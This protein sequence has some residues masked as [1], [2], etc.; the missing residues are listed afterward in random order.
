[1]REEQKKQ[2]SAAQSTEVY[3]QF[4][5]TIT[6]YQCNA[7]DLVKSLHVLWVCLCVY[8]Q[9]T[10]FPYKIYVCVYDCVYAH[11]YVCVMYKTRFVC[12]CVC[13]CTCICTLVYGCQKYSS[14]TF[15][16]L[17]KLQFTSSLWNTHTITLSRLYPFVFRFIDI[18][19]RQWQH[20]YER[21]DTTEQ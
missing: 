21:R 9:F 11:D 8:E 12:A 18:V 1:M 7:R 20:T 17:I 19:W 6:S 15:A 4:R 10:G 13:V 16:A 2:H 5:R 14:N 3:S